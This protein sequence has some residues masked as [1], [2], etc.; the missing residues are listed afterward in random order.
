MMNVTK[1]IY[2]SSIIKDIIELLVPNLGISIL[3]LRYII[4]VE[5]EL[6][7]LCL[8]FLIATS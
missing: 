5:T 3:L 4:E 6:L 1:N 8:L 7:I 2:S